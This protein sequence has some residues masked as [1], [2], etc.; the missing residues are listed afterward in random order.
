MVPYINECHAVGLDTF[1]TS[2]LSQIFAVDTCRAYKNGRVNPSHRF[3]LFRS[4]SGNEAIGV[5]EVLLE[6]IARN[7]SFHLEHS[8]VCLE[9]QNTVFSD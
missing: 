7:L 8:T 5:R 9:M 2:K 1:K 6:H 4:F 3:E